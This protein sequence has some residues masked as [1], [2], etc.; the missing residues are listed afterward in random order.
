MRN[1]TT[2]DFSGCGQYLIRADMEAGQYTNPSFMSTI[3]KKV[4]WIMAD[5]RDFVNPPEYNIYTL[6]DMSDG[7]TTIGFFDTTKDPE[8][9]KNPRN[10]TSESLKTWVW[11]RFDSIQILC[12]YLN[13]PEH[14]Q[15]Y[16]FATQEEIVRVVMYQKS[17]WR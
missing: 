15:E 7:M 12:D 16:R 10:T 8:H 9:G 3:M 1:F 5:K 13:N 2:E 6:V 4:G 17:R 11:N 14:S